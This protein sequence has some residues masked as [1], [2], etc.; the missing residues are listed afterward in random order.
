MPST[1]YDVGLG[2]EPT[3]RPWKTFACAELT[4]VLARTISQK[5]NLLALKL[6]IVISM[7]RWAWTQRRQAFAVQHA[8]LMPLEH[9]G[10][11]EILPS[12]SGCWEKGQRFCKH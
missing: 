12:N 4:A 11:C 3:F 9:G 6:C 8:K 2:A 5:E 10:S 1:S 7:V